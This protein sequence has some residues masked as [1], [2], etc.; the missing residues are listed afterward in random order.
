VTQLCKT[1][2]TPL[3]VVDEQRGLFWLNLE[4]K[5]KIET[6]NIV[7][8]WQC[9]KRKTAYCSLLWIVE[10]RLAFNRP[11]VKLI[12]A[13]KTAKIVTKRGTKPEQRVVVETH[14]QKGIQG[15]AR[16]RTKIGGENELPTNIGG[17]KKGA[18]QKH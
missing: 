18:A 7:K 8:V 6:V 15:E 5:H 1:R 4:V 12:Y 10:P 14:T 13:L 16:A 3:P 9:D 2:Q 17:E 11:H